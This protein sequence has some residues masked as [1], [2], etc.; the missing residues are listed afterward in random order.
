M[1]EPE[2]SLGDQLTLGGCGA[3]VLG[4]GSRAAVGSWKSSLGWPLFTR[5]AELTVHQEWKRTVHTLPHRPIIYNNYQYFT[6]IYSY[7]G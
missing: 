5:R 2:P 6:N 3:K 1:L 4:A 7:V